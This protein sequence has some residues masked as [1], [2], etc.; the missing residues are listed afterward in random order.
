MRN[1]Q[2]I[3]LYFVKDLELFL[4]PLNH[5]LYLN[6]ISRQ[7]LLEL[8][9][10]R[11]YSSIQ[12]NSLVTNLFHTLATLSTYF[13]RPTLSFCNSYNTVTIL[14]RVTHSF[15]KFQ[16]QTHPAFTTCWKYQVSIYLFTGAR[17]LYISIQFHILVLSTCY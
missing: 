10:D 7:V 8:C 9:P 4:I 6:W 2:T 17:G 3:L 11:K 15:C 13:Q 1:W 14:T 12:K 5:N 16:P